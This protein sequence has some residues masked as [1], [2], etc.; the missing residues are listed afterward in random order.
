[1]IRKLMTSVK[2]PAPTEQKILERVVKEGY[3]LRGKSQWITEAIEAF[4]IMPNFTDLVCIAQD[5]DHFDTTISIR[6]SEELLSKLEKA[7]IDV[8]KEY[9]EAEGVKSNIIRASIMQRLIRE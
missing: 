8:R 2:I 9:P 1:M 7:V 4:L 3:K 6:L 5:I